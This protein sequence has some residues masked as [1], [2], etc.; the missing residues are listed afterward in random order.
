[1]WCV[2]FFSSKQLRAADGGPLSFTGTAS[3]QVIIGD[4]QPTLFLLLGPVDLAAG[5][6]PIENVDPVARRSPTLVQSATQIMIAASA[7]KKIST[8]IRCWSSLPKR[9]E[10]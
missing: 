5:K 1:V 2:F 9:G 8:M 4:E 7:T 6:T 3:S 10:S